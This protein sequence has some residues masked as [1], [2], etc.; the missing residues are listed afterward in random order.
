MMRL[1]RFLAGF[2]VGLSVGAAIGLL[3]APQSGSETVGQVRGRVQA[4]L[5]EGREA[6]EQTR[7]DAHARLADL[8]EG[9]VD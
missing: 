6:A 1:M 3:L 9:R 2:I 8:K 4:I 7:A 5:D